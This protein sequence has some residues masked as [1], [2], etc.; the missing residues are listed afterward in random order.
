M[1]WYPC[2]HSMHVHEAFATL[3]IIAARLQLALSKF[4]MAFFLAA[5]LLAEVALYQDLDSLSHSLKVAAR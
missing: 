4:W 2:A 3:R 1:I 5:F